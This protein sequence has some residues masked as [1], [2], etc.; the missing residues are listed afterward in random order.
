MA[1]REIGR[2]G[3]GSC[4][5]FFMALPSTRLSAGDLA[6]LTDMQIKAKNFDALAAQH[7]AER[8]GSC[9]SVAGLTSVPIRSSSYHH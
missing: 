9:R 4:A 2:A 7:A 1:S 6:T 8:I 3:Y 5:L